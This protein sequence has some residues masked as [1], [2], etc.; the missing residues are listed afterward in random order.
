MDLKNYIG[1][2]GGQGLKEQIFNVF[3]K[4]NRFFSLFYGGGGFENLKEFKGV[5]WIVAEKDDIMQLKAATTAAVVFNCYKD[6]VEKN[7]F[8]SAD[9]IFA[10]PPY[11]F[12]TRLNNTRYYKHE[13]D[14]PG[15]VEFLNYISCTPGKVVI[16]H[17][18]HIL[19]KAKLKGWHFTEFNYMSRGGWFFDGI[20]TNYIPESVELFTYNY[21]GNDRT[22]RQQI[23][24]SIA[25]TVRKIQ[26]LPYHQKMAIFKQLKL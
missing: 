15:H 7:C 12:E 10:D 20:W 21:L 22:T 8:T 9:V 14:M 2:K 4:A 19:Y 24:R 16:T 11:I 1:N 3:P 5:K 13:F 18:Y 6:L 17:P 26:E 25:N 23:K